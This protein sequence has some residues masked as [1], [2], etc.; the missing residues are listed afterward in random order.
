M[1]RDWIDDRHKFVAKLTVSAA[2]GTIVAASTL[3]ESFVDG[4]VNGSLPLASFLI[5]PAI[6]A[7]AFELRTLAGSLSKNFAIGVAITG[8]VL[9]PLVTTSVMQMRPDT[10]GDLMNALPSG[11]RSGVVAPPTRESS[12]LASPEAAEAAPASDQTTAGL[13]GGR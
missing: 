12:S 5:A 3:Y 9:L 13:T 8:L 11:V 6:G 7:L 4:F 10:R 1:S 2:V